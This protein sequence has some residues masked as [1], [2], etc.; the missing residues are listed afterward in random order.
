MF[1][2]RDVNET[3]WLFISLTVSLEWVLFCMMTY[4]FV[5]LKIVFGSNPDHFN[6]LYI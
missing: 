6:I 4:S 2:I 3:F 1:S 5:V